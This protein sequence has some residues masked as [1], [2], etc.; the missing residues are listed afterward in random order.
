VDELRTRQ[1]TASQVRPEAA[2]TVVAVAFPALDVLGF[3]PE[4]L[5]LFGVAGG[6]R[7]RL[8]GEDVRRERQQEQNREQG[9]RHH[10]GTTL[11]VAN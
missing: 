6:R 1:G 8:P 3:Q 9:T 5:A 4:G 7:G 10:G 11:P 2:F